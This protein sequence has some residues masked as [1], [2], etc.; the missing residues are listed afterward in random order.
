MHVVYY[1]AFII[2]IWVNVPQIEH[3]C[4]NYVT[5]AQN[6]NMWSWKWHACWIDKIIIDAVG[7]F[8]MYNVYANMQYLLL[9]YC[10]RL[11]HA[12]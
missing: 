4:Y 1:N 5:E 10:M 11:H 2:T 7:M 9:H 3:E 6:Y 12:M 8:T